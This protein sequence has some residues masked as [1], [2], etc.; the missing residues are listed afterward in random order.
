[1]ETSSSL[2]MGLNVGD[3]LTARTGRY[4]N[5]G[6]GRPYRVKVLAAKIK[7]G[8]RQVV[9]ADQPE[10]DAVAEIVHADGEWHILKWTTIDRVIYSEDYTR[11]K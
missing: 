10:T 5:I 4:V 1:M 8:G 7:K 2:P 6:T 3:V 9:L 11:A